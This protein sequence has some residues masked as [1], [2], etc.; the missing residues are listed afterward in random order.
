MKKDILGA[1]NEV[2]TGSAN[3][4]FPFLPFGGECAHSFFFQWYLLPKKLFVPAKGLPEKKGWETVLSRLMNYSEYETLSY[5][6]F[7]TSWEL[8]SEN[9]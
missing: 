4:Q 2:F 8:K 6:G 9:K 7:R 5:K 3:S 1:R